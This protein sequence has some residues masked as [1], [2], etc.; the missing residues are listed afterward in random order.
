MLSKTEIGFED[1][2]DG[3]WNFLSHLWAQPNCCNVE[4]WY[5]KYAVKLEL[6]LE[7]DH[8]FWSFPASSAS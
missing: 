3:F 7:R 2:W 1:I 4:F 5:N 8:V 6:V